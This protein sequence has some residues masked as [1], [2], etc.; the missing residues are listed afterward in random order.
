M[1]RIYLSYSYGKIDSSFL[2][3]LKNEL[4]HFD[5]EIINQ[6]PDFIYSNYEQENTIQNSINKCDLLIAI[7]NE[8]NPNI[9][10]EIGYAMGR[11]KQILIV[12]TKEIDLPKPLNNINYLVGNPYEKDIIFEIIYHIEKMKFNQTE[13]Q[14]KID[15]FKDLIN[16]YYSDQNYFDKIDSRQFEEV[17]ND[18]FRRMH[19]V[20]DSN[21][22]QIGSGYDFVISNYKDY[23]KTLVEVK[24]YNKNAKI[25]I[26]Q[27][28]QFLG[29][30]Y[31]NKADSGIFI[32]TSG[33]TSS[34][35]DFAE[36]ATPTIEL[37]DIN[38]LINKIKLNIN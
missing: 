34:A 6:F 7:I 15:N 21:R 38:D 2:E 30:V 22:D 36:R 3:K 11:G 33:F 20:V 29:V 1:I 37:W 13:N 32:S 5:F 8:Y 18:L 16:S 31:F 9:F 28:Q 25:S 35:V 24:N 26:G 10:F 4:N 23:Q 14:K 17:I 19:Y 27:I 12:G